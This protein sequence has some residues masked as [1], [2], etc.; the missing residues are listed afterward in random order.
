MM[1]RLRIETL[2]EISIPEVAEF[3]EATGDPEFAK[4]MQQI[5]RGD[6]KSTEWMRTNKA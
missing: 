2:C 3:I 5:L 6:Q 4:D 1:A